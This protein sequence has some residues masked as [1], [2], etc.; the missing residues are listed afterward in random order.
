EDAA[1]SLRTVDAGA[2]YGRHCPPGRIRAWRARGGIYRVR[3]AGA[4]GPEDPHGIG[5][6]WGRLPVGRLAGLLADPRP[7]VRDRA[8]REL[9]ARG[10]AAIAPLG[11]ILRGPAAPGR[12]EA[13]WPLA[14]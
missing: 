5:L 9:T 4:P 6:D 8:G 13:V 12:V 11:E 3:R 7:V 2:W 10:A 1:G 14:A